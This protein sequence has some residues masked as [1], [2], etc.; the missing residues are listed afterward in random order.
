[1]WASS[2]DPSPAASSPAP[3]GPLCCDFIL[4][5]FWVLK[6]RVVLWG[7]KSFRGP[8]AKWIFTPFVFGLK[9]VNSI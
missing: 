6:A 1:L 4:V 9:L 3:P 2:G 8:F 5:G 7:S